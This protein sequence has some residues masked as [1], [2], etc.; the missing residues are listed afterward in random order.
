MPKVS[1]IIPIY[2]VEKYIE[3]CARSLFEQ[4]LDEIEYIFVDD[5][6]KDNSLKILEEVISNYPNRKKQIT[7][8]HHDV[9]KGLPQARKTGVLEATGEYIAHCDS[10]DWVD[11]DMY[12]AMYERGK[13]EDADVVV[14]DYYQS[15]GQ[16]VNKLFKG[17]ICSDRDTFIDHL[18]CG[19]VTWTVWNKMFRKSTCYNG[20]IYPKKNMGEDMAL[21]IQ[22]ALLARKITYVPRPFYY[23]FDNLGSIT[24]PRQK[25]KEKILADYM[26]VMENAKILFEIISSKNYN[27]LNINEAYIEYSVVAPLFPLTYRKKYRNICFNTYAG[28]FRRV[29]CSRGIALKCKI[30]IFLAKIYLFP[31][32]L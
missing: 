12:R 14:C 31:S 28:L 15:N 9:N 26:A 2:G 25:S 21:C 24:K 16:G 19:K 3:R 8:L 13:I 1:V 10:D 18:F 17:C 5:K 32:R 23:Y 30:K 27:G 29:L 7:I 11:H 22:S 4:T 20:I 6:T